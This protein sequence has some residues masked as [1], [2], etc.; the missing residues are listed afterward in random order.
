MN[1][2]RG[3]IAGWGDNERN[4]RATTV[5]Q[6]MIKVVPSDAC[7]K[8]SSQFDKISSATTFCAGNITVTFDI[9]IEFTNKYH[10]KNSLF[11][12]GDGSVPCQGDSGGGFLLPEGNRLYVH[13]IISTTIGRIGEGCSSFTYAIFVDVAKYTDWINEEMRQN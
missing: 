1:G 5:K 4:T 13:G 10:F 2:K 6:A 12:G 9:K 7:R 3:V 11:L 8:S